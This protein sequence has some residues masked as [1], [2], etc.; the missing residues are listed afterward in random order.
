MVDLTGGLLNNEATPYKCK[1]DEDDLGQ[2]R[3]N[4]AIHGLDKWNPPT[5]ATHGP[6]GQVRVMQAL[7]LTPTL[8]VAEKVWI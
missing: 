2:S 3:M 8:M 6:L 4:W 7:H 1:S 5:P